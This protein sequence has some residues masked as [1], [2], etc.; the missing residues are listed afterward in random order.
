[1]DPIPFHVTYIDPQG[2]VISREVIY[3]QDDW[4]ACT[5]ALD[6]SWKWADDFDVRPAWRP[7]NLR[8]S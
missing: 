5:V 8:V 3:A 2:G 7:D 6:R 1:M 4:E